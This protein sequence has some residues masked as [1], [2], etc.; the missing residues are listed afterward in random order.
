MHMPS[1]V[2]HNKLIK[3]AANAILKHYGLFQKG[4]SRVWIE[5]NGWYLTVVEFQPSAWDK[6]TYL[7][8][9]VHFLW[10]EKD[11]LSY[12]YYAGLRP[13]LD[14]FVSFDGDETRFLTQVHCLA[15]LALDTVIFYRKLRDLEYA[16]ESIL[17]FN[18]HHIVNTLYQRLMICGLRKN[19]SARV[20]YDELLSKLM[21]YADVE[22]TRGIYTELTDRIALILDDPDKLYS[23]ICDK[24]GKQRTF[25]Q[26]KTS[27]KRM[28]KTF[29]V[30]NR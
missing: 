13:R 15:E 6:G 5:D 26:S 1:N 21:Q 17:Q 19:P 10:D 22:W 16:E 23:Y 29:S 25:W 9:S 18:A 30:E 7:N 4:S 8:V 12:D 14:Q 27:M 2:D 24:I 11:Y 20:Y 3:Q 28:S